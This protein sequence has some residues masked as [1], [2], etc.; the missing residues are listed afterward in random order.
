MPEMIRRLSRGLGLR[1]GLVLAVAFIVALLALMLGNLSAPAAAPSIAPV[2]ATPGRVSAGLASMIHITAQI[3]DPGV[4]ASSVNLQ[5]LSDAGAVL[6]V[7]GVLHDDGLNGDAVAGDRIYTLDIS[8]TEANG[9]IRL[10]VSA[11]FKGLLKR[12]NSDE[13]VLQSTTAR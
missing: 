11:G 1:Y 2:T 3:A 10:R 6:A 5:R 12:I 8:F 7:V 13:I 4:I 9:P